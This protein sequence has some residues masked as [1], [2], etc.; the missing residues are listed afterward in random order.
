MKNR[1]DN[2]PFLFDTANNIIMSQPVGHQGFDCDKGQLSLVAA[3]FWAY[4][5]SR[6]ARTDRESNSKG[7]QHQENRK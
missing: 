3:K 4:K 1:L 5:F 6:T 7:D 2:T